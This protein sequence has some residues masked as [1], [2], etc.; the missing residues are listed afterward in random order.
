MNSAEKR[1]HMHIDNSVDVCFTTPGTSEMHFVDALDQKVTS[2]SAFR[3]Q[4]LDLIGVQAFISI[5]QA[6]SFNVA[7]HRLYISP[8]ALTRRLQKLEAAL[9]LPLIERTTRSM[10][11]TRVGMEFLPKAIRIVRELANALDELKIKAAQ[12]FE[13]VV[14]DC[15]A[16][17]LGQPTREHVRRCPSSNIQILERVGSPN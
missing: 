17:D 15:P 6:G 1:A 8:T 10:T 2:L 5:A 7:A 16:N 12:D 4:R 3:M 14:I 13:G 9:G 11:V